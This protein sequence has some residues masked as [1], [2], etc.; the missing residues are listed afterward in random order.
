[1]VSDDNLR[2]ME[3]FRKHYYIEKNK[4]I[5]RVSTDRTKKEVPKVTLSDVLELYNEIKWYLDMNEQI[6]LNQGCNKWIM[7]Q[8]NILY[9]P[10]VELATSYNE[11]I[12]KNKLNGDRLIIQKYIENPAL[13][14]KKKFDLRVLVLIVSTKPLVF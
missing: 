8:A 3:T 13:I 7:K 14:H 12:E 1:M 10:F 2:H 9:K 11:I 6:A 4:N 5:E